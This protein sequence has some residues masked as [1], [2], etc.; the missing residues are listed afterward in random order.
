MNW[1]LDTLRGIRLNP[2]LTAF[3]RGVAEA[4]AFLVLYSVMDAIASGDLANEVGQWGPI[5]L[6]GFRSIEGVVD[7]IDTAKQ[8]QRD[9]IRAD[10]NAPS[11][12]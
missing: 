6:V 4:A 9:A 3:A 7:K 8:R 2:V 1:L 10:P 11:V 12:G 5:I